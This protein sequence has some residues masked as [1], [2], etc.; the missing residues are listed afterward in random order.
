MVFHI[1]VRWAWSSVWGLSPPR[2]R[3]RGR[4]PR[5]FLV[6]VPYDVIHDVI[7]SKSYVFAD[8][9]GSCLFFPVVENVLTQIYIQLGAR[10][11]F[12]I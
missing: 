12:V 5:Q 10:R 8:W 2:A 6:E 4:G 7:V 3:L 1:A 9:Q 11:E